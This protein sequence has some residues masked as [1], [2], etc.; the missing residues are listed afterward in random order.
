LIT[1][2]E[3]LSLDAAYTGTNELNWTLDDVVYFGTP[4]V[5]IRLGK[6][7]SLGGPYISTPVSF[8]PYT[9]VV[10]VNNTEFSHTQESMSIVDVTTVVPI[11]SAAWL[12][13]SGLIGLIGIARRKMA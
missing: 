10:G 4:N 13:G 2:S 11:P 1:T 6:E 9:F 3:L 7:A 12:F 5:D 8:S